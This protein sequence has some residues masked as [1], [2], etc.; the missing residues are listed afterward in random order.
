MRVYRTVDEPTRKDRSLK[1]LIESAGWLSAP[2]RLR[3]GKLV[4]QTRL[5]SFMGYRQELPLYG[6]VRANPSWAFVC[7][8]SSKVLV[9]CRPGFLKRS[10]QLWR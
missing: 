10:G 8:I 9:R 7:S 6:W 3:R 1:R 4:T 2:I 5:R